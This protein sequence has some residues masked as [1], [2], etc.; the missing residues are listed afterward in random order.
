MKNRFTKVF[1]KKLEPW[2][3]DEQELIQKAPPLRPQPSDE[4]ATDLAENY[5]FALEFPS[6]NRQ[7][8]RG[9]PRSIGRGE[10]NDLVLADPTVSGN[11]ARLYYDTYLKG[12]CIHDTNSLNGVFVDDLPASRSLLTDGAR[13]RLGA[14]TLIFRQL[15]N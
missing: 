5:L 14:I 6:G 3:K 15:A 8:F 2:E 7:V 13:I 9:L 10:Q 1:T 12:V 11:H 4:A